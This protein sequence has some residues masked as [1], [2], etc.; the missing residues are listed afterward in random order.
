MNFVFRGLLPFLL[1]LVMFGTAQAETVR[2]HFTLTTPD[3][4]V[5][6]ETFPSEST[7]TRPAII[8]LSGAKGFGAAAYDEMAQTLHATGMDVFLVHFLSPA[9]IE[10]INTAGSAS[11]RIRYYAAQL[12]DWTGAVQAAVS[13]LK[14]DPHHGGKVG[15]I[16]ISLGAQIAAAAMANSH[17][18]GGLVLVDGGFPND[19]AE[20]VRSMPPLHLIWGEAD[21]TFPLPV[22]RRLK[23][24]AE[25]LGGP[26]DLE[27]FKGAGHDFF[28]RSGTSQ[29][30]A[31]HQSA[32]DFLSEALSR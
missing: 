12:S 3:G 25:G 30:N 24:T 5:L 20:P 11:A 7:E 17:D 10:A 16:G 1:S 27:V 23:Q 29:G 19:Y 26:V 8:I 9:D 32:A 15:V 31:A 4:N 13:Y 6:V 28:V 21:Q 22:G 14:A 2:E 18:I